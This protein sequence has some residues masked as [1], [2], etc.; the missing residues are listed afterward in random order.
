M[1]ETERTMTAEKTLE[2]LVD[3][4]CFDRHVSMERMVQEARDFLLEAG[5][6][7]G[8]DFRSQPR[9]KSGWAMT[10]RRTRP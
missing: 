7:V 3:I 8:N 2:V 6:P 1:S 10:P 9:K 4:L 5:W